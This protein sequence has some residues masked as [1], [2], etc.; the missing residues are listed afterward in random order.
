ML[1]TLFLYLND[2]NSPHSINNTNDHLSDYCYSEFLLYLIHE[3]IATHPFLCF[4][5]RIIVIR[6]STLDML[7]VKTFLLLDSNL[8]KDSSNYF[9]D[10][11][12]YLC[13]VVSMFRRG[14]SP[15]IG[16]HGLVI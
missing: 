6:L 15:C 8:T 5:I 12:S 10:R 4:K 3:V 11:A 1:A 9:H 14:L 2:S 7:E 13:L 16:N